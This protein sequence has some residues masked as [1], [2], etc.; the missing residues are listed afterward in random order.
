MAGPGRHE[1]GI[2]PRPGRVES[3]TSWSELEALVGQVQVVGRPP[4]GLD[5]RL[6]ALEEV[7]PELIAVH[8]EPL[9]EHGEWGRLVPRDVVAGAGAEKRP[10]AVP[11][12]TVVD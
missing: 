1:R 2:L 11:H 9:D 5:H 8:G 4:R 6:P 3:T 10:R 7:D 12:G